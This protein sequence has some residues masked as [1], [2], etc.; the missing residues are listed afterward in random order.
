MEQGTPEPV[1]QVVAT[2]SGQNLIV[3]PCPTLHLSNAFTFPKSK[4]L[5]S[6]NNLGNPTLW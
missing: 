6:L 2:P 1:V 4:V 3:G 5:L